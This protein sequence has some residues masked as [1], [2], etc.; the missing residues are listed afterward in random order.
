MTQERSVHN[1]AYWMGRALDA[2]VETKA[3]LAETLSLQH[4][5]GVLL[6]H[7]D[8]PVSVLYYPYRTRVLLANNPE[9]S[10][11]I[12]HDPD[13]VSFVEPL[14]RRLMSSTYTLAA[15][16]AI[17]PNHP[18]LTETRIGNPGDLYEDEAVVFPLSE[19]YQTMPVIQRKTPYKK[20]DDHAPE[21][22]VWI[23][24]GVASALMVR[25]Y[26]VGDPTPH[27]VPHLIER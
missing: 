10:H 4:S 6:D 20:F 1:G 14:W 9:L 22:D 5:E 2:G 11:A 24:N 23:V 7:N 26:T 8:E 16:W 15:A 27:V 25:E 19:A 17:S 3:T 13:I 12:I 21:F 18:N